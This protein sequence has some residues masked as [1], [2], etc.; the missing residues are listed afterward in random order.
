MSYVRSEPT[1]PNTSGKKRWIRGLYSGGTLC[2][3]ATLLLSRMPGEVRSNTP[4]GSALELEDVWASSGHTLIDL[5]A[6][7]FT[8]G[9]PHP[10][11]DQRLRNERIVREAADPQVAVIL[12]DVV[13]GYGAH[14]DPAAEIAPAIRAARAAGGARELAFVAFVC[15][16]ERDPQGLARQSARLREAGVILAESNAH[17]ARIAATFS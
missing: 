11:I 16:T 2:Y 8:R 4:V 13:L 14:P 6:D 9:R 15:G 3:E 17:A 5:G 7:Q 1:P 12:L 10:M